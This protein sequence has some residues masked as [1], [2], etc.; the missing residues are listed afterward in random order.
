MYTLK[1]TYEERRAID[2]IG[3]RYSHGNEL[4]DCLM[5]CVRFPTDV[6]WSD[7]GDI[8]FHVSERVA[9][10]IVSI[11]EECDY[12]FDCFADGLVAKLTS[13]CDEVI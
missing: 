1:L 7:R 11:A 3:D 5:E 10:A 6:W 8:T 13:F 9:W 12:R 2:W 4:H